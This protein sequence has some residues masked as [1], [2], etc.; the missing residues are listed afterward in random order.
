MRNA[1]QHPN[2][3]TR[4]YDFYT[5]EG[6]PPE[7]PDERDEDEEYGD[8]LHYLAH[9]D[10]PLKPENWGDIVILNF[11]RGCLKTTTPNTVV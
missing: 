7:D 10:G 8:F 1:W 4:G 2:D 9:E 6:P 11:A 5:D 3:P